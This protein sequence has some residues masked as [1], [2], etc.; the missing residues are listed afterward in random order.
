MVAASYK[1]ANGHAIASRHRAEY[2]ALCREFWETVMSFQTYDHGD[3]TRSTRVFTCPDTVSCH[4]CQSTSGSSDRR[5]SCAP[6]TLSPHSHTPKLASTFRAKLS[7]EHPV[8][9][10][11]GSSIM[12]PREYLCGRYWS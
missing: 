9:R 12:G 7:P 2:V 3:A 11:T 1:D 8:T 10:K 6:R 5:T 4:Q